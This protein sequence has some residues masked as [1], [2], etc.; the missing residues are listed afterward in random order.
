MARPSSL[1]RR[2]RRTVLAR[3]RGLAALCAGLAVAVAMQANAAPA[4]PE[5]EVLVAARDLSPGAVVGPGDLA[6]VGFRPGSVPDGTRTSA[7]AVLGRRTVGPV[8]RGEPLTDVRL[9]GPGLLAEHPGSVAVPVR[10]ADPAAVRLLRVGDRVDILAADAATGGP[11]GARSVERE[12]VTVAAAVPVIA[13]PSPGEAGAL[14]GG[15]VLVVATS[16]LTAQRLAGVG[17]SSYLS[18]VLVG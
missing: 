7:E 5:V 18:A 6:R 4:P 17:V 12:A 9:L 1:I 13:I 2:V 3:R 16:S 15:A 8:R 10:L 11:G 14:S